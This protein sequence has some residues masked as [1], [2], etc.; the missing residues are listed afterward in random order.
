MPLGVLW[1]PSIAPSREARTVESEFNTACGAVLR[2]A[3][4]QAIVFG[5]ATAF[6]PAT[7]LGAERMD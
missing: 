2:F 4:E 7:V 1:R 5:W 6:E 3:S